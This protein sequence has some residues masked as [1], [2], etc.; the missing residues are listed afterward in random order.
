MIRIL[1]A[2][3]HPIVRYG[4]SAR[5][6]TEEDF[7]VVGEAGDGSTTLDLLTHLTP[8]VVLLDVRLPGTDGLSVLRATHGSG[9]PAKVVIL[10]ASEDKS[11]FVEALNLGCRGIL[12]KQILS[13]KIVA[14]IRR[15][16]TTGRSGWICARRLL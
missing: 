10:T 8:D 5:L 16:N 3:G 6:S 4:L 7:E 9:N 2:D 14:C 15:V 1:I 13:D 12:N 11:Q